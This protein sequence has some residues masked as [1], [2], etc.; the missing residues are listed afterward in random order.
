MLIE[1]QETE[2]KENEAKKRKV[3]AELKRKINDQKR[4]K[5]SREEKKK[6]LAELCE[7]HP[8]VKEALKIPEVW[9][10]EIGS[11][12]TRVVKSNG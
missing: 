10:A 8:H 6:E 9:Q 4:Q 7:A 3:E 11:R 5:K 1:K 12:S 2:L